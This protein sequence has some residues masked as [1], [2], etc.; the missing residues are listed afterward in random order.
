MEG[1]DR[2]RPIDTKV[3]TP[4]IAAVLAWA[5]LAGPVLCEANESSKGNGFEIRGEVLRQDAN[6]SLGGSFSVE[7]LRAEP[8]SGV[9]AREF[10]LTN[11][12]GR[13]RQESSGC[14]CQWIF[15]DGFE[16]GDVSA[17]SSSAGL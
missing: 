13:R 2:T 16:S 14:P 4:C 1:L 7:N 15:V 8:T 17:W 3:L 11:E 10:K 12:A 9:E 5:L 6:S